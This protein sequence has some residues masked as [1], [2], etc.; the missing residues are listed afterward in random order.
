MNGVELMH[1]RFVWIGDGV[2]GMCLP[3]N[4]VSAGDFSLYPF[5]ASSE[6]GYRQFGVTGRM[7]MGGFAPGPDGAGLITGGANFLSGRASLFTDCTSAATCTRRA[8]SGWT[9]GKYRRRA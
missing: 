3:G 8:S 1:R 4:R 5:R 7:I 2:I 9:P 6:S